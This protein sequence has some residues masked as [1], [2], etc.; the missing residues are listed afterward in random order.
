MPRPS[1]G[2]DVSGTGKIWL[3]FL[4]IGVYLVSD[5]MESGGPRRPPPVEPYV[6]PREPL[7]RLD[8]QGPL[9]RLPD[10]AGEVPLERASSVGTAFSLNSDGLWVTA[11]H[12]VD[13]CDQVAI[14]TGLGR[15]VVAQRVI[16][17]PSADMA[18]IETS[19]GGPDLPISDSPLAPG[20][21]GFHVGFPQSNPG[22]VY[23]ILIG[24]T[25]IH[26]QGRYRLREPAYI[27]AEQQ[28]FPNFSGSLGGISGGPVF[29]SS[30]SVV[31]VTVVEFPRRGR[32]G[33]TAPRSFPP[34]W[35]KA[36]VNPVRMPDRREK[37]SLRTLT[38]E[39]KEMRD[40]LTVAKVY[41]SVAPQ[42]GRR[43]RSG[44]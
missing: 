37:I 6:I 33:T 40:D 13:S 1:P 41:C 8:P 2:K 30:G 28:R 11:R 19:R 17:H 3:A 12:V 14:R 18:V 5:F 32:I 38:R 21:E 31:G 23:S 22:E 39:S 16:N 20:T 43:G 24:R 42:S 27:W 10:S 25:M 15:A 4:L 34:M 44:W 29:D 7:P 26:T 9:E 35:Q 36:S